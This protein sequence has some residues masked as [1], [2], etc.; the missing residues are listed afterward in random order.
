MKQPPPTLSLSPFTLFLR[1]GVRA[2]KGLVTTLL[3]ISKKTIFIDRLP[4][5]E[6]GRRA[7]CMPAD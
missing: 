7:Q 1:A 3:I 5:P 4:I 2:I 6:P